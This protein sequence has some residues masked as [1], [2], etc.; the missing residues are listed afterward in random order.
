MLDGH[1]PCQPSHEVSEMQQHLH[2]A[3]DLSHGKPSPWVPVQQSHREVCRGQA[4]GTARGMWCPGLELRNVTRR[5]RTG[6]QAV[7]G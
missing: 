1:K 6:C 3:G 2:C 4:A 7:G 5:Q